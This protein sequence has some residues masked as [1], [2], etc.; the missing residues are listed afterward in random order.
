MEIALLALTL[1]L[2]FLDWY[3]TERKLHRLHFITKP[4]VIVALIAWFTLATGWQGENLWFGLGLVFS[5]VGDIDLL[6]PKRLFLLGLVAF[7]LAHICYIIGFNQE[8]LQFQPGLALLLV[9]LAVT[10]YSLFVRLVRSPAG[11]QLRIPIAFYILVISLMVFSTL[12][13]LVRP[14]WTAAAAGFVALGGVLFMIS[15][16]ILAYNRFV[17]STPHAHL[18]VM[19]TYHLAQI[20][21][22]TGVIIHSGF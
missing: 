8:P 11:R 15:D 7:M 22:I 1:G 12:A 2:A 21:L 9:L 13:C 4:L 14:M 20:C 18:V 6:F 16:S 19:S 3:A 5:L 10:D 17:R